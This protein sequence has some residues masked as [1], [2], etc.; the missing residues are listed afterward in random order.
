M[1]QARNDIFDPTTVGVY[2]C[3]SRCV[4]RAYLCGDDQFTGKSY[5]HRREVIRNR[6]AE[7]AQ[8][9][10]I[11]VIGYAVM[12]NHYHILIKNRPDI[13]A[14]WSIDEVAK[15]W[16]SLFPPRSHERKEFLKE[17]RYL[18]AIKDGT[19]RIELFRTRLSSISWF[20]RCTNEFLA[21]VANTEDNCT[22]RFWEGRFKCQRVEDVKAALACATYVDLNPVRAGKADSAA[23]SDYTSI[24]ERLG[25]QPQNSRMVYVPMPL[26][27]IGIL[28]HGMLTETDY[29]LLVELSAQIVV[30]GKA[31]RTDQIEKI[32][33]RV[34][35][36]LEAW[37]LLVSKLSK[38]FPRI[39]GSVEKIKERAKVARKM[40]F[41]GGSNSYLLEGPK[42]GTYPDAQ[43]IS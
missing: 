43:I 18:D 32:L 25:G 12:N 26:V 33:D 35:I 24:Q 37:C 6:L 41:H 13:A 28:T 10:A 21:C 20:N 40:W 22:G 14:E 3:M 30:P 11:E 34:G 5:E 36:S 23:K 1:T 17:R 31:Y 39:I 2:H 19:E 9:F 4:R 7:L 29:H 42:A 38:L 15:R 8:I 27:G 16:L